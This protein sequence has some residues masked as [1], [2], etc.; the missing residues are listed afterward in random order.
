M[1]K[2]G[3]KSRTRKLLTSP[4][5]ALALVTELASPAPIR[6]DCLVTYADCV[7]AASEEG[8]F[9]RRSAAGLRCYTEFI[10]CLQRRLA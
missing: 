1:K 9:W 10:S 8:T 6:A 4:L 3:S 7:D 2:A 5:A